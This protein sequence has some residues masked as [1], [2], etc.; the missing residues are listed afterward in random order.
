[1]GVGDNQGILDLCGYL[2]GWGGR[3]DGMV[4]RGGICPVDFIMEWDGW[5]DGKRAFGTILFL[6]IKP[7]YRITPSGSPGIGLILLLGRVKDRDGL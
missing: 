2:G 1:M 7:T 6:K 5:G 3:R 4:G